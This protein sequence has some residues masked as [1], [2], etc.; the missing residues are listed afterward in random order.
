MLGTLLYSAYRAADAN[1]WLGQDAITLV[2]LAIVIG[3]LHLNAPDLV[4]ICLFA[5]LIVAAVSNR[6]FLTEWANSAPLLWL[7]EI[8][9]SLYLIHCFVQFLADRW[10]GRS[11]QDGA[12]LPISS[13]LELMIVMV[14]V[15]LAAAHFSYSCVEIGCRQYLR[16][17]LDARK[18]RRSKG[19]DRSLQTQPPSSIVDRRGPQEASELKAS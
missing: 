2:I 15:C 12:D 8:S 9:Y 16:N 7:G 11:G 13:S 6:G 1:A 5:C 17:L 10:L 4:I 14:G 19:W 3:C 18:R